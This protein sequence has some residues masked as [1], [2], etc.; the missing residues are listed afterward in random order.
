MGMH[1]A[2]SDPQEP[3]YTRAHTHTHTEDSL[4][5]G[6]QNSLQKSLFCLFRTLPGY[7]SRVYFV[8]VILEVFTIYHKKLL[9]EL[10]LQR[11]FL[12]QIRKTG[13][14]KRSVVVSSTKGACT[15]DLLL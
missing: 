10:C 7:K 13:L 14:D 4:C 6:F 1:T 2:Q 5:V 3:R 15:Q 12:M 8:A 11:R 9:F